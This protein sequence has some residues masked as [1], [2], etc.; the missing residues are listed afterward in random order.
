MLSV[1][2]DALIISHS[3][4]R[5]VQVLRKGRINR[6]VHLR[7]SV[8]RGQNRVRHRRIALEF[9]VPPLPADLDEV[10][11]LWELLPLRHGHAADVCLQLAKLGL[12]VSLLQRLLLCLLLLCL[13]L[14]FTFRRLARL[15]VG[16]HLRVLVLGGELL[17]DLGIALVALVDFRHGKE[18]L[19]AIEA[20]PLV[21]FLIGQ[22][23]ILVWLAGPLLRH[24]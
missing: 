20:F 5:V 15:E 7:V 10:W 17:A 14:R 24:N 2:C 4:H 16:L 8:A 12:E 21:E 23:C 9:L 1:R 22:R 3:L 11:R 13:E 6:G 19:A 18:A